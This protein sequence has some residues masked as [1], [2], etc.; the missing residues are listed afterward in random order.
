MLSLIIGA[1]VNIL[2]NCFLIK[3][4]GAMGATISTVLAEFVLYGVQFWT[5]RRDLD[6][7]KYLKNG[8]IFYLFG[9][10]MYLAI[11]AVKAH[12]QYNIINLVLLIVLGG[13]VY[14]GFC[15]FY[16]LISRNVHFEIL[17]EKI[18]RK[19]GYENIL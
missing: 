16:I 17:R 4:F 19:I 13:I 2:L 10:I 18:K 5:V 11:I 8:F 7:K 6:F 1:L 15:C 12:L 14:T 3:P 9:M